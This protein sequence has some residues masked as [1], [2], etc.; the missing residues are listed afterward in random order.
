MVN[1]RT[2]N[3]SKKSTA[4]GRLKKKE[5]QGQMARND[6]VDNNEDLELESTSVPPP[7]KRQKWIITSEPVN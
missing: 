3:R 5:I 1:L 4:R 7:L 2:K 6:D